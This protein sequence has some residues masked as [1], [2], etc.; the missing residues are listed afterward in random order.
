MRRRAQTQKANQRVGQT[1][2]RIRDLDH[3]IVKIA[4]F[5]AR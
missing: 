1:E 5:Q 3:E 2:E 4:R